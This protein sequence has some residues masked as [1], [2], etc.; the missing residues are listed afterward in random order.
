ML[1]RIGKTGQ[2]GLL[3][4]IGRRNSDEGTD[5]E[6]HSPPAEKDRFDDTVAVGVVEIDFTQIA[7]EKWD[8]F[9]WYAESMA[10]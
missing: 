9:V 1:G 6:S 8:Y 4:R 5:L 3:D 10:E 2:Y 7:K